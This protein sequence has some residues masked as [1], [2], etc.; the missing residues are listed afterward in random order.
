M[1]PRPGYSNAV[2]LT[3][4][5]C[6]TYTLCIAG[7]RVWVRRGTYGVDDIVVAAATL[8]SLGHTAADYVALYYGLGTA[9][10]HVL[11][12]HELDALNQVCIVDGLVVLLPSIDHSQVRDSR[13]RHFRGGI[14]SIEMRIAMLPHASHQTTISDPSL[15]NRQWRCSRDWNRLCPFAVNRVSLQ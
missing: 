2:D 15:P 8:V 13:H 3:I 7:I 14:I 5:L 1:P 4:S 9:W 11:A 6:L 12:K 10:R